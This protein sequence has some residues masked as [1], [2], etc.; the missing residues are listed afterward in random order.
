MSYLTKSPLSGL[1]KSKGSKTI[2]IDCSTKSLA[3]C[4]FYNRR[5]IKWGKI[6]FEGNDIYARIADASR[7]VEALIDEFDV[8]FIAFEGAILANNRNVDVTIKLSM[9]YGAVLSELLK[10]RA[11]VITVKPLDWQRYVQNPAWTK[12]KKDALKLECPGKSTSW[13][14]SEVRRRRKQIT[15]D[16][17]NKKWPSLNLVDDD[18]GDAFGLAY[19]SYHHLTRR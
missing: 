17:F 1:A 16:Y 18:V 13:Y 11:E 2:G 10:G 4:V 8:D 9:M 15:M 7:K 19:Y 12:A 5:P 3:F 6:L 14:T